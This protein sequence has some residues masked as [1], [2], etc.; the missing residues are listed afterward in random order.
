MK[1]GPCGIAENHQ[2][3]IGKMHENVRYSGTTRDFF[4]FFWIKYW[5]ICSTN[6]H[7]SHIPGMDSVQMSKGR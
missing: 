4:S 5:K 2:S 7:N 1:D 6:N 3:L